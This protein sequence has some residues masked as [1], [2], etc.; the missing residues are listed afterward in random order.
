MM[1]LRNLGRRAKVAGIVGAAA[2]TAL[3]AVALLPDQVAWSDAEAAPRGAVP[4]LAVDMAALADAAVVVNGAAVAPV[5]TVEAHGVVKAGQEATLA[6]RMTALVTALPYAPGQSFPKGARLAAFDCSQMKAQLA[7]AQAATAAYAKT[8]DTNV[9]LDQYKAIGTNEVAVSKANLGKASAEAQAIR[10]G[11][12]Q[13]AIFAPFAGTVVE[14]PAHAHDVAAPGQPL[15]KIQGT[16][17]MEVEL[18]VPSAW[19]TWVKPG[20]PFTFAI[21]E[22]GGSVTGRIARLGAAVDPVSKTMRVTGTIVAEGSVVPGMSGTARF[23][24]AG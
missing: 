3:V 5:A 10:A 15:L 2:A 17:G 16:G 12:D 9:E 8:Y 7:A 13:C 6:S 20:T 14:R 22:T 1:L 4:M 24:R 21:D 19:L 11:I 18:I 23:A